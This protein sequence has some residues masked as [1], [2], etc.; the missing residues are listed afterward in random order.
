MSK[1]TREQ[2]IEIYHRRC[3][4]ESISS[5]TN[6]YSVSSSGIN[7]LVKLIDCHGEAILRNDKNRIYTTDLKNEMIN[8]VLVEG[9]S[10]NST[11]LEY[12]L[13]S[14]GMLFNWIKSYKLNG[15][16]IVE[17]TRGRPSTMTCK[18]EFEKKYEDMTPEEKVKF[19]ES[20]NYYLEAENE[21]L[22][23]LSAVVQNR[24]NQL[25]KKK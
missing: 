8:K 14:V 20:K 4:G 17:K 16:V 9:Q 10:V 3:K 24:K 15:C 2:K 6:N 25:P 22:K 21:Y 23:K 1:L 7:Y 12:G 13:L 19:L 5:L 18:K 11:A